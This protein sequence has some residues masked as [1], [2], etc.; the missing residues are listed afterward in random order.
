MYYVFLCK[1]NKNKLNHGN[2][3]F[4]SG[5]HENLRSRE[6]QQIDSG[7]NQKKN[8]FPD[9]SCNCGP[10][11]QHKGFRKMNGTCRTGWRFENHLL[12]QYKSNFTWPQGLLLYPD[13]SE[14]LETTTKRE[15]V[16]K[17]GGRQ[18]QHIYQ[19]TLKLEGQ[20]YFTTTHRDEYKPHP[21]EE[22]PPM[23]RL[24]PPSREAPAKRDP[25]E[26]LTKYSCDFTLKGHISHRRNLSIPPPDNLAVNQTLRNE[27]R[28]VQMDAFPGWDTT[29][30]RRPDPVEVRQ[31]LA[32]RE[33]DA[34]FQADTVTKLEFQPQPLEI[35]RQEPFKPR[36][37]TVHLQHEP[38]IDQT[39]N[40]HFL[41]D[42]VRRPECHGN[43]YEM[44]YETPQVESNY[45]PQQKTEGAQGDHHFGSIHKRAYQHLN[46]PVCQLQRYL[47]QKHLVKMEQ[48]APSGVTN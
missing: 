34:V 37:S 15:F 36:T 23:R 25:M 22:A 28:T 1:I 27:F 3:R 14:E 17:T 29:K 40:K 48:L 30:H 43:P 12:S 45:K 13:K 4:S 41:K 44:A 20:R 6:I 21:L 2:F 10:Y 35:A 47:A 24:K 26:L 19:C 5:A 42:C 11:K 38:F 16:P 18:E 8:H 32:V 46:L 9:L 39:S 7:M 31:E 33:K